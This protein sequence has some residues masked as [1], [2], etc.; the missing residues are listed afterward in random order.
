VRK[1][2]APAGASAAAPSGPWAA[3]ADAAGTGGPVAAGGRGAGVATV[4]DSGGGPGGIADG[5]AGGVGGGPGWATM[6]GLADGGGEVMRAARAWAA[7]SSPNLAASPPPPADDDVSDADRLSSAI[8]AGWTAARR[9]GCKSSALLSM[10]KKGSSSSV[11]AAGRS[12][13]SLHC[14]NQ[15]ARE[16]RVS[17]GCPSVN[18]VGA[19]R[20]RR[21]Q[22][23]EQVAQARPHAVHGD[24]AA[25][26]AAPARDLAADLVHG[27]HGRL[28]RIV[29]R[30]TRNHL[31]H[32]AA[33]VPQIQFPIEARLVNTGTVSSATRSR[34]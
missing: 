14:S 13:G 33:E 21:Q 29:D 11:A 9:G 32:D 1:R 4:G 20:V 23:L 16:W 10:V 3:A 8:R 31:Q 17:C 18:A 12:A 22:G 7:R 27:R 5:G 15:G 24:A 26:T 34:T 25:A 2:D 30:G 28:V 19:S 6:V